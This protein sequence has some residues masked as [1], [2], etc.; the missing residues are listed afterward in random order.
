MPYGAP[1]SRAAL[2]TRTA[3]T[4]PK[5]RKGPLCPG[6]CLRNPRRDKLVMTLCESA[7]CMKLPSLADVGVPNDTGDSPTHGTTNWCWALRLCCA[8]H[9]CQYHSV[10]HPRGAERTPR[11]PS[12]RVHRRVAA[13][14][15]HQHAVKNTRAQP[16]KPTQ[17]LVGHDTHC[18]VSGIWPRSVSEQGGKQSSDNEVV[19][20]RKAL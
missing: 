7:S 10:K 8:E 5:R 13:A 4:R 16:T 12:F 15:V 3:A 9:I 6:P 14:S 11:D 20:L 1:S 2:R 17:A 18:V 19:L